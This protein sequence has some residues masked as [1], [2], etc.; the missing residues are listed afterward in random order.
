M[1]KKLLQSLLT[2]F[3]IIIY[4]TINNQALIAKAPVNAPYFEKLLPLLLK[5]ISNKK[6]NTVKKNRILKKPYNLIDKKKSISAYDYKKILQ[7]ASSLQSKVLNLRSFLTKFTAQNKTPSLKEKIYQE[8]FFNLNLAEY[9]FVNPTLNIESSAKRLADLETHQSFQ[10]CIQALEFP[11]IQTHK[12]IENIS[13]EECVSNQSGALKADDTLET[14]FF[15][16][17]YIAIS[18]YSSEAKKNLRELPNF[19]FRILDNLKEVSIFIGDGGNRFILKTKLAE[20]FNKNFGIVLTEEDDPRLYEF[21]AKWLYTP[22][23][24]GGQS[25]G[26]VDCSGLAVIFA[27]SIY[28]IK[29]PRVAGDILSVCQP[30]K[31]QDL[32]QGDF[33]F[34]NRG[35]YIFH[36]G[37]YLKNSKFLHACLAGGVVIDNIN[38]PYYKRYYYCGGRIANYL[39]ARR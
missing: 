25:K 21:A 33:V 8:G 14:K 26:G 36:M 4:L 5:N 30:L 35:N 17:E 19:T 20:F 12:L 29:I 23:V 27:D 37:I 22:Y 15:R 32:Q 39:F 16:K 11:V 2:L 1:N 34:F 10:T 7:V 31:K 18:S 6:L 3:I 24:W 13:F 28:K 9:D 38:S